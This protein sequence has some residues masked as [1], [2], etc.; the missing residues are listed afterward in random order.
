MDD[1]G[2][3]WLAG[4]FI[5]AVVVMLSF[6]HFCATEDFRQAC[7]AKGGVVVGGYKAPRHC[8]RKQNVIDVD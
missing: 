3:V 8:I 6:W 7:E 5:V 4:L 1:D 2:L